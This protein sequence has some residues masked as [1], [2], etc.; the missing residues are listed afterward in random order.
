MLRQLAVSGQLS[1]QDSKDGY[2][3]VVWSSVDAESVVA[4]GCRRIAVAILTFLEERPHTGVGP[5]DV[6]R[7]RIDTK[8]APHQGQKIVA[9]LGSDFDLARVA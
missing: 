7:F 5:H 3:L 8:E 9:L 2:S 1:S 6:G 4:R